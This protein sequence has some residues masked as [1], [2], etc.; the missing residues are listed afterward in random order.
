MAHNGNDATG[1]LLPQP[2]VTDGNG[3]RVRLDD[4][5]GR[6]WAILHTGPDQ[7]WQSWRAAGVPVIAIAPPGSAP[8]PGRV[9]D[10][11]DALIRWLQSKKASVVAVRPDG[12]VY[13]AGGRHPL[14]APPAGFT[15]TPRVRQPA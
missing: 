5:I 11:D 14:P 13:A 3:E 12:F 4:V 8:S 9:V 2:W 6:G 1:W 10:T 15:A 7:P